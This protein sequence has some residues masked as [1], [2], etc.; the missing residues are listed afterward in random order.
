M[1]VYSLEDEEGDE[2]FLTQTP[3]NNGVAEGVGN[4]AQSDEGFIQN[5]EFWRDTHVVSPLYEDISDDEIFQ[6]DFSAAT[7]E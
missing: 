3:K 1:D 2:L 4:G 6:E 7:F 5:T